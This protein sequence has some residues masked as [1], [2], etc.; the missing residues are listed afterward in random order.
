MLPTC[1]V[2]LMLFDFFI[3]KIYDEGYKLWNSSLYTLLQS[4]VT[5][6]IL[7]PNILF[8]NLFSNTLN[9]RSS[10]YVTDKVL[11]PYKQTDKI[12]LIRFDKFQSF[13]FQVTGKSSVHFRTHELLKPQRT[14][15]V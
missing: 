11:H 9:P 13:R 5:S 3:L 7:G 6:L 1:P 8:S 12:I 14:Y 15:T 10:L 4:P 2:H